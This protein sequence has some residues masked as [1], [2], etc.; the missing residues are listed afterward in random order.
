MHRLTTTRE[1]INSFVVRDFMKL[2]ILM[3]TQKSHFAYRLA[4]E[5]S[6]G[7]R[8]P[9]IP[10]HRRDLVTAIEGNK[11]W[12]EGGD[13]MDGPNGQA[14]RRYVRD[15]EDRINWKKFEIMGEV[16]V[17]VQAAQAVPMPRLAKNEIVRESVLDVRL[18]KD[19]DVSFSLHLP[20]P[21][22]LQRLT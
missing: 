16:V 1:L 6:P 21:S 17:G 13:K 10:L 4:W 5:N 19:D 2:E 9:Y 3:G 8:I 12:M 20:L 18:T 7:E 14:V 15:G 11:T 22:G